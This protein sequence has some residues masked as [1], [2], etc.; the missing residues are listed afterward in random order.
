[1]KEILVEKLGNRYGKEE[2]AQLIEAEGE[3]GQGAYL[4]EKTGLRCALSVLID[5]RPP[6]DLSQTKRFA[7]WDVVSYCEVR[8]LCLT[9]YNDITCR[10]VSPKQRAFM[11]A[12]RIR[13]LEN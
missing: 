5:L 10:D 12:T 6:G 7:F 1:M 11:V 8:G 13:R 2:L 3:L 4:N 9:E